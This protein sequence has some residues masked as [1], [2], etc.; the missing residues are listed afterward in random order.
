MT[1]H[2]S[3]P[4]QRL[5]EIAGYLGGGL[6]LGGATLL[7][8]TS[9]ADLSRPTRIALLAAATVALAVAAL[10]MA[11]GPLPHRPTD[12][13][14]AVRFRLA[15]VLLALAAGTTA[16][17]VGTIA[18]RYE[19][20]WAGTAGLVVAVLGYLAVR[21]LA[22]VLAAALLSLVTT[23][24]ALD[25][26][27]HAGVLPRA[28]GFILLG[29]I[30]AG[31]AAPGV[32]IQRHTG[33]AVGALIALMGAQQPFGEPGWSPWGYSLTFGI[34][35]L[36]LAGYFFWR[37]SPVL[38]GAGILGITIA[39]PEAVWEWTDGA[40]GG[41]L[42]ALIA[43]AVLLAASGIGLRISTRKEGGHHGPSRTLRDSSRRS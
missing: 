39:I 32:L 11:E 31:L 21:S 8:A 28:F 24:Q 20:F 23:V 40:V 4:Q 25:E 12:T 6:M 26:L 17:T 34:A 2:H 19:V 33:F 37:P 10:L 35:L 5:A 18:H 42:I 36:W 29:L 15:G 16:F 1:T 27:T 43:G 14:G 13:S 22:I 30:W 41:A 38:L 9:W 7:I 3:T